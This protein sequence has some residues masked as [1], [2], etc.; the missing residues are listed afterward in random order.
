MLSRIAGFTSNFQIFHSLGAAFRNWYNMIKSN[1]IPSKNFSA[2]IT[3]GIISPYNFFLVNDSLI[4]RLLKFSPFR[5]KGIGAVWA[6]SSSIPKIF[7]RPNY[8]ALITSFAE[9]ARRILNNVVARFS[10]KT[11][12]Y[13]PLPLS[14]SITDSTS[15]IKSCKFSNWFGK[16]AVF[17]NK[18]RLIAHSFA[19]CPLQISQTPQNCLFISLHISDISAV[20]TK[21]AG[22]KLTNPIFSQKIFYGLFYKT[23]ATSFRSDDTSSFLH[24]GIITQCQ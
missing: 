11:A 1:F 13:S 17:T 5:F 10:G 8:T 22:S 3:S 21:F 23:I 24:G 19:F 6:L 18:F 20:F 9:S 7:Q 4:N 16:S 14:I 2:K 15:A 12:I